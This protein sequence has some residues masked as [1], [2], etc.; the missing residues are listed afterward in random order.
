MG[1]IK[2]LRQSLMVLFDP[3]MLSMGLHGGVVVS[4]VARGFQVRF[5]AG[6]VLC[7]VFMFS[8]CMHVLS[9]YS[10]FPPLSKNMHVK[11]ILLRSVGVCVV[12][13]LCVAL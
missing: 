13:C 4:T 9:G 10:G 1:Q 5:P 6:A 3:H 7:G 12:V 11:F 8:P 2:L